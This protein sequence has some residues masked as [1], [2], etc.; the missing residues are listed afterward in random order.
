MALKLNKKQN[1]VK[2]IIKKASQTSTRTKDASSKGVDQNLTIPTGEYTEAIGRRKVASAR[3]RIYESKGDF[4]VNDLLAGQ[5]FGNI[6]GAAAI[7][8]KPF[9]LT[10]TKGKFSVTVRVSGS[11][12]SSQLDAMVHGISRA[13]V[14]HNPENRPLLKAEGLLTRDP[15][16]KETRKPGKGGKAR[17]QRQSP[18]R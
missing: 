3:V 18:K 13:L 6:Q 4:I 9:E 16:M 12:I 7:Y 8:N 10:N 17:R 2:K 14:K 15:R 11:G 5:Y 1:K